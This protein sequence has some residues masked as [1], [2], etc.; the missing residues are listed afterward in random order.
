[1][2]K[3]RDELYGL[4]IRGTDR[5]MPFINPYRTRGELNEIEQWKLERHPLEIADAIID[6][7]SKQGPAGI[8][9]VPGEVER[10]KW[11]GIYPQKQGGDAFMMRVKIP[12]GF[13]TAPQIREIGV[14]ADAFGEG[15]DGTE[16]R[17]F[18]SRYADLTTR[19]T[20]QIHWLRIE[21]IPRIWRRFAAVGLTTVQACGDSARNVLSCPVS[22]VDAHE[23]FDA[24]PVARAVSEFFTGNR[25]YANLPR[26]F[27]M[28]VTGCVEDCAQAEINDIGLWPARA[29][30]GTLGF[31][32]LAG[33]GLSDG[34]RMASDIDVFVRTDQAVEVTRAIAQLFG[35]LGNR[36]NRG[37]ARMRYLVQEL[38]PEGFR[39]E[40]AVRARFDLVPAG[41]SLTRRYRGDHV[42]VHPQKEDGLVYVGC[43]VPVGR[44]VGLELVE[45]ARLAETYGDGTVRI[46]T[47][48]NITFTGVPEDR[49][50]DLLSEDLVKK[51]SPY[52]GPFTRGVVAC[53]GSEFCRYAIVETKERAVKW[54]RFLDE[55]LAGEPVGAAPVPGVRSGP[56]EDA[57]VIR[58]HFSGCS[59]SC[60]QPQI[61]DIGFRGEVAYVGNHLAEAVD[62]GL[63]GSLGADA[64]FIDWVEHARPVNDVPDAL[65]RVVR[66]YQSERREDEPFYNWARRVPNDDLRRTLSEE[67]TGTPVTLV[68]NRAP[69]ATKAATRGTTARR[70]PATKAPA[71]TKATTKAATTRSAAR[72][73]AP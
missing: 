10:L 46:G 2:P 42:G 5:P 39:A 51:Y 53:T 30:D 25:E 18:G 47:D 59:A 60:A 7:Y 19:Q 1:M 61:A 49:L 32:L 55:Q 15:P 48:Q 65:L 66:R 27:K 72:K 12:G 52:P 28:S 70:T 26:K 17:V 22:G 68:A 11:A 41:E 14:A 58:M 56:R 16:S 57:G 34:E 24:L 69:A 6:T 44:M 43:S 67:G 35:E 37:Q 29:E 50:D 13:L 33:G 36:E 71:A 64:G 54:A 38:G 63:G 40:L 20:V 23:A 45:A 8:A 62:I 3:D 4:H 21:D 73:S 31:N 9:K